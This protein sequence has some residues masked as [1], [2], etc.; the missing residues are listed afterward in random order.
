MMNRKSF[1]V[2]LIVCC[3]ATFSHAQ[4]FE[5]AGLGNADLVMKNHQ[6]QQAYLGNLIQAATQANCVPVSVERKSA[7]L[8]KL[9]YW[10]AKCGDGREFFILM[11]ERRGDRGAVMSCDIAR[12]MNLHC[13]VA[14]RL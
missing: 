7:A 11:P 1:V 2:G 3:S 13:H 14:A 4:V 10:F 9:G 8:A 12:R 6:E 5:R